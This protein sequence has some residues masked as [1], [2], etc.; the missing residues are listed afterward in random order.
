M[1]KI[2]TKILS[3]TLMN[4]IIIP[5]L[6]CIMSIISITET[7]NT[8]LASMEQQMRGSFDTLISTQVESAV[9][10]LAK[11]ND[12]F[13]NGELSLEDAK[14]Q[15]AS[16]LRTMHFGSDGYFWADTTEGINV[17]LLGNE[18]E[19]TNRYEAKDSYGN[20][21]MKDIINHGLAEG[22]GF[23]DYYFPKKGSNDPLPKRSYSQEY[24]P[25]GW[26][27]GTGNYTNDI[28]DIIL[29]QRTAMQEE[30][31]RKI[32]NSVAIS[33]GIGVI[34][35]IIAIIVGKKI[36]KPIEATSKIIEKV[37][38]GDF[39]INIPSRY[40]KRKDEIGL[41]SKALEH[42]IQNIR[43]MIQNVMTEST[44]TGNVVSN[45][46][47]NIIIL[48]NKINDVAS[49]TEQLSAGMEETA[50]YSEEMNATVHEIDNVAESIAIKA[51]EGAKSTNEINERA[52]KLK[53]EV[54][55]SQTNAMKMLDD[56]KSKLE[57]AIV[58]SRSVSQITSLSDV[59]LEITSQTNLLALNAAIEA[60]R[61]GEAGKGF[62]VVADEIR[63]LAEESKRFADQITDIIHSL[64]ENTSVVVDTMGNVINI[65][66]SQG[67]SVKKT[68]ERFLEID[69]AIRKIQVSM[70]NLNNSSRAVD[71]KKNDIIN[72]IGNLSEV[73]ENNASATQELSAS[74]EEQTAGIEQI[75]NTSG[76]LTDLAIEL[77][78][79]ISK[80]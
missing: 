24:K 8:A 50:A 63:K 12:L 48:Q 32:L 71:E 76:N 80:F 34:F 5:V 4:I 73:S 62:A 46:Y 67:K 37:S 21:Y 2:S 30:T 14:T 3:L 31:Q 22:G 39:T 19:G 68:H 10:V 26:V 33:V 18:T 41:I 27:I 23:S 72:L 78:T 1:K 49:T 65:S 13:E 47:N 17:V 51:Q 35:I 64:T 11:Y 53:S 44:N 16:S 58:Q 9:S 55:I 56:V 54:V 38:T 59:I 36:A 70:E 43:N 66:D 79:S 42:M 28:D 29:A 40:L 20:Y 52:M 77:E 75:A 7:Q 6:L 25:F 61:A 74:I 15:A 69:N 57:D 60:A 45:V